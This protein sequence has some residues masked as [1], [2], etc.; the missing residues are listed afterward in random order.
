MVYRILF[1]ILFFAYSIS[2]SAQDEDKLIH[3]KDGKTL[4]YKKYLVSQCKNSY[5]ATAENKLIEQICNCKINLLDR[6]YTNK[7][8]RLY[9]KKYKDR[10]ISMLIEEDTAL[11]R[12]FK[13]CTKSYNDVLFLTIP[14]NRQSFVSKC[15]G[16]LRMNNSKPINDTL[17]S[18][19][20]N[21][22]LE[23]MEKRKITMERFDELS[24]PSSLLYNEISYKC[25]SPFLEPS[26]FARDWQASNVNDI[27]G[28][29]VD[30]VQVISVMGMHKI[31]ITIGGITKVWMID[32]GAADL[33][34][35]EEY[36]SELKKNG[37]IS[38]V[39]YIGEGQYSLADGSIISCKRYKVDNL[40]IG[41]LVV[42]NVILAVSK[43]GK[44]FLVGKSLLNKFSEWSIDN[45]NNFLILKK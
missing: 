9:Q 40:K 4:G 42:N 26:D 37:F 34:I 33:L 16:N 22:A 20:C 31:K 43:D 41:R 27:I 5:G 18:L 3:S 11:Q 32:S 8:I 24:D 38:Q 7:E 39:N 12:Q 13:E 2:I 14:A 6:R 15:L 30:S 17:G 44:E 23:V 45:K 1:I 29:P 21:C 35:S 19:F 25:G 36:A 28:P 10:G